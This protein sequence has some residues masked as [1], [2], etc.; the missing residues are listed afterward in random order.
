MNRNELDS[1]A[2]DDA[3]GPGVARRIAQAASTLGFVGLFALIA[4]GPGT[5]APR[6]CLAATAL[7]LVPGVW[8]AWTSWQSR[9]RR[10]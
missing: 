8:M 3:A 7:W 9:R 1:K 10:A 2:A 6:T 5:A 4:A